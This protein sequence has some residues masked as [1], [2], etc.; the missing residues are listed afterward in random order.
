MAVENVIENESHFSLKVVDQDL[1][2]LA[3]FTIH[4][5]SEQGKRVVGSQWWKRVG[6]GK[7]EFMRGIGGGSFANRSM[8]A[9]D[10]LG[11]DGFVVNGGKIL[12]TSIEMERHYEERKDTRGRSEEDGQELC[13][14]YKG[15]WARI[16]HY[17][18]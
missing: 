8:V 14:I 12:Y 2:P 6:E 1:S 5:M 17:L 11:G 15:R 10:G 9:K 18:S 4:L 7:V 13:S 16:V 3:M